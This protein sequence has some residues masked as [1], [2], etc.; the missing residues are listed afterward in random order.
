MED[1]AGW[2]GIGG[3]EAFYY[4]ACSVEILNRRI[5]RFQVKV[6]HLFREKYNFALERS[7][8]F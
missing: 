7:L 8:C 2:C 6:G 1:G 3:R 5:N 4:R